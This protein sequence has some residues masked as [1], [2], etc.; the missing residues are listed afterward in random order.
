MGSIRILEDGSAR[1]E[2]DDG[3]VVFGP[4]DEAGLARLA[5]LFASPPTV[6]PYAAP[7]ASAADV[8]AER[9]RRLASGFDYDFGD[10]RGV[11]RI[12]ITEQD[13]A[14]WREVTDLAGALLAKGM[15]TSPITIVT[16]TGVT[17]VMPG[18]WQ[19]V[20]LA[21]AAFRQPI[22]AA[23]FTLQ[24]MDPIP[25]DFADDSYWPTA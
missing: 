9:T 13:L 12:G 15:T 3:T 19:E 6:E 20:L 2:L 8:V 4:G 14:G 22:W 10:A 17:Q 7:G 25:A 21:A 23:S 11:H 5:A 18:E 24:A 16:D 1:A